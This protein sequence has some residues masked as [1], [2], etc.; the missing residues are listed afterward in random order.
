ML[1]ED[2]PKLR[3]ITPTLEAPVLTPMV[4]SV[5][6]PIQGGRHSVQPVIT[7]DKLPA[8]FILPDD[9]VD[10]IHQP[11]IAAALT[12][13]LNEAG[14]IAENAFTCTDYGIIATVNGKTIAKAPDWA[15]VANLTVPIDEVDR[16]YTPHLDGDV[17]TIVLEFLSSTD[18]TEYSMKPDNPMGKWYYYEQILK[19]PYYGIFEPMSGDFQMYILNESGHY[20]RLPIEE[21]GRYWI[22]P[23]Q[24]SIAAWKGDR[25]QRMGYWLRFWDAEG[26]MLPW[27]SENRAIQ[28]AEAEKAR[29]RAEQESQRAE[30]E[31]QRAEQES[32]RADEA[33]QRAERL[34]QQLR[35]LGIDPEV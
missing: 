4:P 12:D 1:A 10:N 15:Y 3:E 23:M 27:A 28:E 29:Q 11:A 21:S 6:Q 20:D 32:Q 7:W 5:T 24:L 33:N 19:V 18:G 17:P 25:H 8:D 16:S 34:A 26:V 30:Q 31:S 13:S 9:P 22:E 14:L 35:D 2:K